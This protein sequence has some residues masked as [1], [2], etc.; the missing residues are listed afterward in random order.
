M[1]VA[2]KKFAYAQRVGAVTRTHDHNVAL[3]AGDQRE[4]SQ[5]E[6]P[7]EN[8]AQLSVFRDQRAQ[9]IR[10]NLEEFTRLRHAAAHQAALSGDHRDLAG[11]PSGS[12]CR[13][14][15]LA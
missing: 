4:P 10:T 6:R 5:D 8:L 12:M 15:A 1:S 2:A 9:A 11:E 13:Y 14:W 3:P 7:H